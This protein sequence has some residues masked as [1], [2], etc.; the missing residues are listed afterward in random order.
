MN[1]DKQKFIKVAE[2]CCL[3][4]AEQLIDLDTLWK[5]VE[6]YKNE[7]VQKAFT[8]GIRLNKLE[9]IQSMNLLKKDKGEYDKTEL[10]ITEIKSKYMT[11][12]E[13]LDEI[14]KIIK[15]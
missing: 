11:T 12:I 4:G 15:S 7:E 13:R 3:T 1:E 5:Y 2:D 6:T 14:D 8:D 9:G 10:K